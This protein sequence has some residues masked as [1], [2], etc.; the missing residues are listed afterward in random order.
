MPAV[1]RLPGAAQIGTSGFVA[2]GPTRSPKLLAIG[3]NSF[4]SRRPVRL[5]KGRRWSSVGVSC[6]V[7]RHTV[8][9][10]NRDNHGF[11]IGNGR[12]KSF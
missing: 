12:Y 7:S 5:G 4:V 11:V 8:L 10:F 3:Q 2:L 6:Q 1:F 9:C